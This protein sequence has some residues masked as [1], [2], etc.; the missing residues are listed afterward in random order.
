ML[1]HPGKDV[2]MINNWFSL[3]EIEITF[4]NKLDN[5]LSRT[6]QWSVD[7]LEIIFIKSE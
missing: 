3:V 6:N 5:F 4:K 1:V 7:F 2:H